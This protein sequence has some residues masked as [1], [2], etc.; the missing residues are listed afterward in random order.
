MAVCGPGGYNGSGQ[1]G[2]GTT[3]HRSTPLKVLENV[4]SV[5]A[6]DY[7]AYAI[8]SDGSLWSWG[9]NDYGQ[10]GDGTQ[11]VETFQD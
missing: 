7:S 4:T 5:T 10:L 3:S 2:D 6:G 8:T 1:V 9:R 11:Q